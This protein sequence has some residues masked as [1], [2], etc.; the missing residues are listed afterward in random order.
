MAWIFLTESQGSASAPESVAST[1]RLK[2]GLSLSPIASEIPTPKELSFLV[3][4]TADFPTLRFG[5]TFAPSE[6][7]CSR[8][9]ASSTEA[10]LAKTSALREL[11]QAW[12]ETE[13]A[14]C[15]K[16]SGSLASADHDSSCWKTFQDSFF[17]G[18]T[19]FSWDS[20]RFGMT[21]GGLLFQPKRLE[22]RSWESDSSSWPRPVAADTGT[23][24]NKSP[25]P[26]AKERPG[27]GAIAK[28]WRWPRPL[29]S[30]GEKGG[31]NA[32]NHGELKLS[33]IAARWARPQARDWKGQ[34][35]PGRH[36]RH[37]ASI[38]IQ[39]RE[40]GHTGYLSPLFHAAMM[41]YDSD[42]TQLDAVGM[43]WFHSKRKKPS[44]ASSGSKGAPECG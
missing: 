32:V 3:F 19:K 11:E 16:R 38:D 17:E 25:S 31:P 14:L 8:Q 27:L 4:E 40:S 5:M 44:A 41:G 37:S 42:Y 21:V 28:K 7:T 33:A 12:E 20:M 1:M 34:D 24:I 23:W 2:D 15:L 10:P 39:V 29:A 13:A 30:D 18:L 43:A 26:G 9:S 6:E 22:P 36:G 35:T